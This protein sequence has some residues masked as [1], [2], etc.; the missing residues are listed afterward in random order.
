MPSVDVFVPCRNYGNFL[1]E[2][3]A[4]VQAQ[5][6]DGLRILIID[7]AS[8]DNSVE[9]ACELAANDSRISV[10]RHPRDLGAQ[11]SFNEAIE[12]AR[13][14]YMMILCADDLL[15]PEALARARDALEREPSAIMALGTD[16]KLRGDAL[17]GAVPPRPLDPKLTG[18]EEFIEKCCRSLGFTLALGAVLVRVQ[19]QKAVGEFRPHLQY[20]DD[21]EMAL[22]LARRGAVLEFAGALG[23]RREHGAQMSTSLFASEFARLAERRSAFESF[24]SECGPVDPALRWRRIA[25][26]RL[27]ET[28]FWSGS[29]LLARARPRDALKMIYYGMQLDPRGALA[30]PAGLA[31]R[32]RRSSVWL[33][34]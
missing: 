26:R 27:A 7:N 14:D 33:A 18:G 10:I 16:L 11:A 5:K 28:A 1:A 31:S 20:T 34:G 24:F 29:A 32:L 12:Q 22:R 13:A 8:T 4:S 25:T 21:L 23:I 9:V 19:V 2:C 3:V 6:I 30:I 17:D 15:V